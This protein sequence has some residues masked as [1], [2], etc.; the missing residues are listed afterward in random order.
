VSALWVELDYT[1][2]NSPSSPSWSFSNTPGW[3]A[4]QWAASGKS[5]PEAWDLY[6]NMQVK[7]DPIGSDA[8]I[9]GSGQ[10]LQLMI[11]LQALKS[12]Q[13]A[14]VRLEGRGYATSSSAQFDV[15]NPLNNC[16]ASAKM[17]HDWSVHGVDVDI[18]NCMVIGGGTQAVRIKPTVNGLALLRVRLTLQGASW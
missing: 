16:G 12:Y 17:A 11:G 3:G 6:N 1:S 5:W 8:L 14:V 2:A 18:G 10:A 4:K 13:K 15:Y 7:W 9:I